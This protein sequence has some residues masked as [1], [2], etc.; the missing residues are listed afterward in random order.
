[1][2]EPSLM[3]NQLKTPSVLITGGS[4]LI[5]KYLTS[6]LLVK[7]YNVSH[8]SRSSKQTGNVRLFN[9]KPE[10]GVIDIKV[11][12]GIDHIVH[13]AGANIGEARWTKKRKEEIVNSRV[14][15]IGLLFR[16]IIENDIK[17]KT[18]I[19][20]SA[21]GYY[22]S[23]T[24]EK[25]FTEKDL[26]ETD[27]LGTTCRNWEEAADKFMNTGIRTVKIRTAVVLDKNDS[28]LSKLMMPAKFGFLVQT[29]SGRQYIPWIHIDDL[30]NI[31]LKAIEDQ[32]MNG[33]YN[34]VSPQNV[35]HKEF[36]ETLARVMGKPLFPVPVPAFVI[37]AALGKMSDVVLTG[38][39]ISSEK[40][41]S[42]GYKFRYPVLEICLK[43]IL[44]R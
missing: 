5:G 30:C 36:V 10:K 17:L 40:I 26:P 25:I 22:G 23:I 7:G 41:V 24:S 16:G 1:M 21:V 35:T 18:F 44:V 2:A 43:N 33:A 42:S 37:R 29:G 34:A 13:L 6:V 27:F 32:D 11:F 38:S 8:L 20:A 31:Y 12:E 9:W 39:R 28:A 4:G 19:S 3:E 14:K 15:T